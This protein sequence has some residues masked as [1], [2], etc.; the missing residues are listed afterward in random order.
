MQESGSRAT[1]SGRW[2]VRSEPQEARSVVAVPVAVADV[3]PQHGHAPMAGLLHNR[4][5]RRALGRRF[6]RESRPQRVPGELTGVE[7]GAGG[8][9]LDDAGD[10][11]G[12]EPPGT[13]LALGQ[14]VRGPGPAVGDHATEQRAVA[15]SGEGDPALHGEDGTGLC[16]TAARDPNGPA[17]PLLVG[18][19]PADHDIEPL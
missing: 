5:L 15:D 6:R 2:P 7:P 11:L 18:L 4:P 19:A 1:S 17:R 16:V 10:A 3:A 8:G 12:A 9:A 13:D 14:A